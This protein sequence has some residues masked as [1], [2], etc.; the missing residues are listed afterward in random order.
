MA[1]YTGV[2][3]NSDGSW[4][5]RIKKKINNQVVD[6]KIKKDSHGLPFLTARAAHEA[7]LQHESKLITGEIELPQKQ[8]KTTLSY[9]YETYLHIQSLLKP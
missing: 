9:I 5:Y 4:S 2:S 3:Q 7:K 6:T 8:S 1:K